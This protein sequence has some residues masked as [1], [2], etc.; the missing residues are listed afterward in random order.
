MKFI[1]FERFT[2]ETK[3]AKVELTNLL[4]EQIESKRNFRLKHYFSDNDLKPYEGK[5]KNNSF[6]I[7][8]IIKYQNPFLPIITGKLK[9]QNNGDS[10]IQ[11]I[12]RIKYSVLF[13]VLCWCLA[14]II[15]FLSFKNESINEEKIYSEILVI[16]IVFIIGFGITYLGFN[17]ERNKS[18]I[19]LKKLFKTE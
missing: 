19:F 9:T 8:R 15:F 14:P 7:N 3:K 18:K 11:I 6:K 2:I 1:P 10:K 16:P 13:F 12:M 5:I 17:N 4:L